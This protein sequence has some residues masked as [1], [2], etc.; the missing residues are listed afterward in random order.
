M[1]YTSCDWI[2]GGLDFRPEQIVL[3]CF[4]WLQGYEEY[5]LVDNYHGEPIDWEKLFEKKRQLINMQKQGKTTVFC[6]NCI[7]QKEH[8]WIDDDSINCLLLNH[9]TNCNSSCIYCDF[10]NNK[11][12]FENLVTY[13]I[14]PILQDMK[15]KGFLKVTNRSF[16]TFGGGEPTVLKN[17]DNVLTFLIDEGFK[18]IRIN[19]SGIKY[20]S[21][22]T[23]GLKNDV[24]DVVIS[25]DSGSKEIYQKIKRVDCFE[26]VW[27][28]IAEY[29]KSALNTAK[30]KAKYII[31]PDVNDTQKDIDDFLQYAVKSELKAISFSVEKYWST[32]EPEKLVNTKKAQEVYS[33]LQYAENRAKD[34]NFEVELYS[35]GL[36]FKNL[37]QTKNS[38]I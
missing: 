5:V 14:V 1:K 30:V 33:L 32:T 25:V 35:E 12:E 18:N 13:D 11:Q 26:K 15:N 21:A 7:Y 10:G 23:N 34:L 38:L 27:G 3:C 22:I 31:V 20:S 2:N 16:V 36:G 28:N 24:V 29:A 37:M 6:K 17:F 9:F 4:S 19:S 8:D